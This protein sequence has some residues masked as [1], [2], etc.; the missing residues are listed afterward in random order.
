MEEPTKVQLASPQDISDEDFL[1]PSRDIVLPS[2]PENVLSAVGSIAKPVMIKRNVFAKNIRNHTELTVDD[3]RKI[4]NAALTIP[5]LAINDKPSAKASYWVLVNVDGKNAIVTIDVDIN[6]ETIEVVGWRWAR[7][8][9]LEQIK[10]RAFNEGGQV[11]ITSVG[12]AGLS[13]L[14]ESTPVFSNSKSTKDY[15]KMQEV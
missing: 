7:E 4:L 11:L 12:A 14:K 15:E 13:A 2:L 10:K 5:D 1:S 6:K 9:S 3:S 8:K